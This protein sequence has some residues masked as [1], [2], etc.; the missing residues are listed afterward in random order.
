[1]HRQRARANDPHAALAAPAHHNHVAAARPASLHKPHALVEA[2]R[3]R[4]R[5]VYIE[6]D[7]RRRR[8][9]RRARALD[10]IEQRARVAELA[11]G[12]GDVE[13]V[14]EHLAAPLRPR[15]CEA[16]E[17]AA[18]EHHHV[19]RHIPPAEVRREGIAIAL[20]A[21]HVGGLERDELLLQRRGQTGA[22]LCA[23]G[24]LGRRGN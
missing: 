17:L 12:G 4:I 7:R 19:R 16:R 8:R 23:K 22:E 6:L 2:A 11:V 21:C 14:E 24:R 20:K 15:D 9:A 10:E 1:M 5:L 3:A 18:F 13:L